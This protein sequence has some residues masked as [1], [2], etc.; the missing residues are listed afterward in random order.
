MPRIIRQTPDRM[1]ERIRQHGEHLLAIFPRATER[2][3]LEL[4]RKLRR[5][6]TQGERI[7]VDYCN[8]LHGCEAHEQQTDKLLAKVNKLLG[9]APPA[10]PVFFNSDPRGYALKIQDEY[11]REHDLQIHRDLGG[12]G[13][14]APD[15]TED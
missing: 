7:A 6:E 3:P 13:I 2:D 12:Y 9:N 1:R 5:L 15:L 14:I 10:V 8:G 11:V 4:C